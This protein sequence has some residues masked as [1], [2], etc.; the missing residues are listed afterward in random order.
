MNVFVE[1]KSDE[2]R[3]GSKNKGVSRP[4]LSIPPFAR[5]KYTSQFEF[6]ATCFEE[7]DC[8][9]PPDTGL[10][11]GIDLDDLVGAIARHIH[12]VDPLCDL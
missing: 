6:I 11:P 9:F 10:F 3:N 4:R 12:A 8:F 7:T 2:G 5:N 1:D